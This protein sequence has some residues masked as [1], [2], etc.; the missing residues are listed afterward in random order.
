MVLILAHGKP[1]ASVGNMYGMSEWESPNSSHGNHASHIVAT[2]CGWHASTWEC[3]WGMGVLQ[4]WM[5]N[6]C[7]MWSLV[8]GL[9]IPTLSMDMD[10][11]MNDRGTISDPISLP[12]FW[13][14]QNSFFTEILWNFL[15]RINRDAPP[16]P[17]RI[18][19]K[20]HNF[21]DFY[22]APPKFTHAPPKFTHFRSMSSGDM[23]FMFMS[24]MFQDGGAGNDVNQDLGCVFRPPF[25]RR[26]K[27]AALPLPAA[28]LDD[29]I[30]GTGNWEWGHPRWRP[31]AEGPPSCASASIGVDKRALYYLC[32]YNCLYQYTNSHVLYAEL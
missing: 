20:F 11:S 1:Q 29:L 19:Q 28:I 23:F 24:F 5:K 32:C 2:E 25:R 30:P 16:A 26:R 3:E 27:M 21:L 13:L 14:R 18:P 22:T 15:Y 4:L 9:G 17:P 10:V 8:E 31:E 12:H 6:M 7:G